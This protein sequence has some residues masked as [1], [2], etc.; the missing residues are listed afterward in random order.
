MSDE[1]K[2]DEI[3]HLI[4]D[5]FK[6]VRKTGIGVREA[7]ALDDYADA[8]QQQK[9]RLEDMEIHW[10]DIAEKWRPMLGTALSFTDIEGFRFL[11]PAAMTAELDGVD[12]DPGHSVWFHL[13]LLNKKTGE[14][15][16]HHGHPPYIDFLKRISAQGNAEHY[17]LNSAQIHAVAQFFDWYMREEQSLLY[18]SREEEL[19]LAAK[20]HQ[21]IVKDVPA[22]HYSLT[23]EDA[24]AV[25][26][27][28]CRIMQDWLDLGGVV[29]HCN[30][31]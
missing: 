21:N 4:R 17:L 20:C 30:A 23:V 2:S 11:L 8:E 9:A 26:D 13:T 6:D 22:D 19:K 7:I 29:A 24:V 3:K 16:P 25:F 5:A 18:W 10:W 31:R 15:G 12:N 27:Q 14:R 1:V 28:E